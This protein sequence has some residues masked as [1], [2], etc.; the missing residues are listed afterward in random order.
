MTTDNV[1]VGIQQGDSNHEGA[2][3]TVG[4]APS[5]ISRTWIVVGILALLL[6]L[7]MGFIMSSLGK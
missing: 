3:P 4:E 1:P 5:R 6:G 7:V 2:S